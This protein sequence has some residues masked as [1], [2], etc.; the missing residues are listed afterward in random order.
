MAE[1]KKLNISVESDGTFDGTTIT[2][3]GKAVANL[4]SFSFYAD[5]WG[6]NEKYTSFNYSIAR[7]TDETGI[8][9]RKSYYYDANANAIVDQDDKPLPSAENFRRI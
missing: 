8:S 2:V 3:N 6:D 5:K 7:E 1:E 9:E 4:E